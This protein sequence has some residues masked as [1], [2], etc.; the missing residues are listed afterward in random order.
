MGLGTFKPRVLREVGEINASPKHKLGEHFGSLSLQNQSAGSLD[1]IAHHN[2]FEPDVEQTQESRDQLAPVVTHLEGSMHTSDANRQNT[3]RGSKGERT[4]EGEKTNHEHGED[5][6][7]HAH[8]REGESHR[9]V[10]HHDNT[11][12]HGT[13]YPG[14]YE[15]RPE[16]IVTGW[17]REQHFLSGLGWG[18]AAVGLWILDSLVHLSPIPF[19]DVVVHGAALYCTVRALGPLNEGWRGY[20]IP[21]EIIAGRKKAYTGEGYPVSPTTYARENLRGYYDEGWV[22]RAYSRAAIGVGYLGQTLGGMVHKTAHDIAHIWQ[23][24]ERS[25]R[26]K[27]VWGFLMYTAEGVG[28]IVYKLHKDGLLTVGAKILRT[29]A[30]IVPSA[31]TGFAKGSQEF[32]REYKAGGIKPNLRRS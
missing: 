23:Y 8:E 19:D 15:P 20:R 27:G 2:P 5:Y 17:K 30:T 9:Y 31:V 21:K 28:R 22:K 25:E 29:A 16:D 7:E 1:T 11:E 18:S 6:H 24:D 4:F 10:H 3:E 14:H 13:L 26:E 12:D 32:L